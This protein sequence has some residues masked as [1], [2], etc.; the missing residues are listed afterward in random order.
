MA[1]REEFCSE[2]RLVSHRPPLPVAEKI[3]SPGVGLLS[4]SLPLCLLLLR[5]WK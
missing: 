1:D 4:A 5:E 3:R 2:T